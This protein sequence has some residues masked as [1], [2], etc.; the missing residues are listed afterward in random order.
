MEVN[1]QQSPEKYAVVTGANKGIGL[2]TVRQLA[3][4]GVTVVNNAGASG[5]VVDEARLRAL[6]ID[7]E[8]WLSG[9]AINM[10]QEVI[11]TTYEKAEECLNTN[12]FGVRRVTQALLPLLQLSTSGARI[13]NVSSL[14]SELRRI[15]RE[16]LRNELN[17]IETLN[18]EKLEAILKRFLHDLKEHRLEAGGW[19][20][21]L[22]TYSISKATL[23]AYT[24]VL[25]KRYPNMLI[26]CVHPG[27][28]NT[29]LNWHTGPMT[30]EEGARG[31]V[32]CALLPN[33]GPTG[34]Y[35][36]QTEVAG[37]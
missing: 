30:V 36:D 3:S 9:K 31:P 16:E 23:N 13:V 34:Y 6:N 29:D 25:A 32:K 12:Y 18:E 35:F 14:R 8:T 1:G 28:V 27:Y 10:I 5:V 7:P 37:F 17:D 33:G 2:E 20:L 26:N 22:P 19:S 11:K 4:Q 24:R 15:R 21:M